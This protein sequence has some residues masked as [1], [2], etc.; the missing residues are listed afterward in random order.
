MTD[1][2]SV[3]VSFTSEFEKD[4]KRQRKKYPHIHHDLQPLIDQ[5]SAGETPGDQIQSI[6]YIVYKVRVANRDAQRGKSGGYR[7]IY[8]IRTFD[9]VILLTIYSKSERSDISSQNVQQTIVE[10]PD[11][12]D[13]K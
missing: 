12:G 1:E 6:G 9:H 7:V 4:I 5:L 8:Y 10:L 13:E 3:Q 2:Q 11:S